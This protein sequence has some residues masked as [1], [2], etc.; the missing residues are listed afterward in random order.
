MARRLLCLRRG[1]FFCACGWMTSSPGPPE[2]RMGL[3]RMATFAALAR[4][5]GFLADVSVRLVI[6]QYGCTSEQTS[7]EGAHC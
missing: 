7:A 5:C 1:R 4:I 6:R 3:G 2:A